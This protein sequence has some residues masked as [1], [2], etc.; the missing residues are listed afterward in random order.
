MYQINKMR[1]QIVHPDE[2]AKL[3][4]FSPELI[5][6]LCEL[7]EFEKFRKK[8]VKLSEL[9]YLRF[10]VHTGMDEIM[11]PTLKYDMGNAGDII[12]HGLIAEF[13]EWWFERNASLT[14]GDSFGGCPW[15]DCKRVADRISKIKN[16]DCALARVY[17]LN[18]GKYP[19]YLGSSHL[20]K[21]I[22]ENNGKHAKIYVSDN[23]PDARS[24]LKHSE[25]RLI[26]LSDDN[27]GY[28]IFDEQEK[29][30]FNLILIDPYSKFIL[31]ELN[32]GNKRLFKIKDFV[33]KH[34]NVYVALFI[35]DLNSANDVGKGFSNFKK[36]HLSGISVSLRCPK[37]KGTKIK[38]ESGFDA[39]ILL[40]S[41]QF[42]TN[43]DIGSL[44]ERLK[45]IANEARQILPLNDDQDIKFWPTEGEEIG[46]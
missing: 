21:A 26:K 15:G 46:E 10:K 39:E 37:I 17:K 7:H 5:P 13:C 41:K 40:I 30:N 19:K 29:Y 32:N 36:E 31:E 11:I 6:H 1:N 24:N 34:D 3:T 25:L 20:V 35:L 42:E 28:R 2:L 23:N 38:G 27:D 44:K 8:C 9:L 33:E 22:S 12:K 45:K 16:I 4:D 43:P 14:F 18:Y